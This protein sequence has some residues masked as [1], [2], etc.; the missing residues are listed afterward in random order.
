MRK[1]TFSL[2]LILF[3]ACSTS[4]AG[5]ASGADA[6]A[7]AARLSYVEPTITKVGVMPVK[8][9]AFELEIVSNGRLEAQRK[10]VVPFLV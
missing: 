5:D 3:Y 9:G 10:A 7:E 2:I 1:T 8:R 6:A 4:S